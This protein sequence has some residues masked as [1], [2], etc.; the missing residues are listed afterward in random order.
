MCSGDGKILVAGILHMPC[1]YCGGAG[2]LHDPT[3]AV[4]KQK[5]KH[6]YV[7]RCDCEVDP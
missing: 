3:I 6:P 2:A 4:A 5:P 1:G 7:S